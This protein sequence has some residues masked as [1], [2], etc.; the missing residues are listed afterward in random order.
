M[1]AF[2]FPSGIFPSGSNVSVFIGWFDVSVFILSAADG[3]DNTP[4]CFIFRADGKPFT[5]F[6]FYDII[7]MKMR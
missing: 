7:I 1:K 6:Y 4:T 2:S 3:H 5:I